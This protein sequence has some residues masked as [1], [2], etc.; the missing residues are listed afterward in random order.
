MK[1]YLLFVCIILSQSFRYKN[2]KSLFESIDS[3]ENTQNKNTMNDDNMYDSKQ[4]SQVDSNSDKAL[5]NLLD[6]LKKEIKT[7]YLKDNLTPE[8]IAN[9]F[10]TTLSGNQV[11]NNLEVY[12]QTHLN[13]AE[14]KENLTVHGDSFFDSITTNKFITNPII[15]DENDI[16]INKDTSIKIG[17]NSNNNLTYTIKDIFEAITFVKYIVNICGEKLNKCDFTRLMIDRG[18]NEIKQSDLSSTEN[19]LQFR[20]ME[21][22]VNNNNDNHKHLKYNKQEQDIKST[23]EK[24]YEIYKNELMSQQQTVNKRNNNNNKRQSYKYTNSSYTNDKLSNL[25]SY[26]NDIVNRYYFNQGG[27]YNIK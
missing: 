26:Y 9:Y 11:I 12:D 2:S 8:S 25:D 22:D 21:P 10:A 14:V 4:E 7:P 19:A 15:I 16:I 20:E 6:K 24:E 27:V 18:N 13:N 3:N 5:S 1:F 23:I 17:N